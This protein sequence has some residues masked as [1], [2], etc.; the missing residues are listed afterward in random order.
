M[1]RDIP[2][3]FASKYV[4]TIDFATDKQVNVKQN[5]QQKFFMLKI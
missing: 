4:D 3:L 2:V 1:L 5:L